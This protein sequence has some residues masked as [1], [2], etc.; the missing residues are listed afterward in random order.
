MPRDLA[1][2]VSKQELKTISETVP[3]EE[4]ATFG[5]DDLG[6]HTAPTAAERGDLPDVTEDTLTPIVEETPVVEDAPKIDPDA[7]PE[8]TPALDAEPEVAPVAAEAPKKKLSKAQERIQKEVTKR[9]ASEKEFAEY[10]AANPETAPVAEVA[11]AELFTE[12]EYKV[13]ADA[14]MDGDYG[15]MRELNNRT[16]ANAVSSLKAD[17][18]EQAGEIAQAEVSTANTNNLLK[19]VATEIG[20]E[21][22]ELDPQSDSADQSMIEETLGLRNFYADRGASYPEALR[23]AALTVAHK[24]GLGTETAAIGDNPLATESTISKK[25][26]DIKT[27][28]ELSQKEV[29]KLGGDGER[30]RDIKPDVLQMSEASFAKISQEELAR[31]RGDIL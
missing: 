25:P 15:P 6:E 18:L 5:G 19:T 31:A 11:P 3:I 30:N 10:K 1:N 4:S 8:I 12:E 20:T 28:L 21:Y 29:G 26:N 7:D 17:I 2:N 13:A 16:I 9:K 14:Q 22:P 24:Y 23:E 27:K